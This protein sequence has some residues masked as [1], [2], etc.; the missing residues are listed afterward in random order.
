MV[1]KFEEFFYSCLKCL[2]D[3]NIHTQ[4]TL[5]NYIIDYFQLSEPVR[6]LATKAFLASW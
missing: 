5:R 1:P 3:G 2:N 6:D 4:E